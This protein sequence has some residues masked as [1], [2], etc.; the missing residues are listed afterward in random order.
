MHESEV[1]SSWNPLV[2]VVIPTFNR[3]DTFLPRALEA[4]CNQTYLNLEIVVS[5]NSSTDNT[6]EV[7]HRYGDHRIR[8]HRHAVNIGAA[9]NLE[10]CIRESRGEYTLVLMDDDLIDADFIECCVNAARLAP[11]AGIIRTGSRIIDGEGKV[12]YQALNACSGLNF[13]EFVVGWT[14]GKTMPYLCSTL[15]NTRNLQDV[16]MRSTHNLWN[17]VIAEME[18]AFRF[19]RIDIPDIKASYCMHAGEQ[20]VNAD[21]SAWCDDSHLLIDRVC[22]LAPEDSKMLRKHLTP[23]LA[24]LN[25]RVATRLNRRWT[26]KIAAF[27][28]VYKNFGVMPELESLRELLRRTSGLQFLRALKHILAGAS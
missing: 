21:I 7:V 5:D 12:T 26:G 19:G 9:N 20:T 4:A 10:F 3:G 16:G 1:T 8:Y 28:V 15:F 23:Y 14:E 11:E 17:D 18:I 22:D 25:Y 27:Y 13:V 6:R 24:R 2:T